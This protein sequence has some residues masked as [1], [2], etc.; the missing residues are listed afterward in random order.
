M[1]LDI[2]A[3]SGLEKCSLQSEDVYNKYDNCTHLFANDILFNQS[4]GLSGYYL[5][6]GE[7]ISFRAGS[8]SSYS[9]WREMLAEMMGYPNTKL[10]YDSITRELTISDVLDEKSN[11]TSFIELICLSDCEGTIGTN[12]SRKLYD[13]FVN[14]KEDAVK[15]AESKD[16]KDWLS[17]YDDFTEAFRIASDNGCVQFC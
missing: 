13:D 14:Y 10:L 12:I 6:E 15:Y 16:N 4:C 1:G 3:V 2:R 9:R 5:Y 8:Y 7:S 17:L 11:Y